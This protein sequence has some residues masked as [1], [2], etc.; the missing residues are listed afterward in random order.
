MEINDIISKYTAGE[1]TLERTNAALKEIGAGLV[2]DPTHNLLTPKELAATKAGAAP[3]EADGFGLLDTGT[4][5]LNK[6]EVRGGRLVHCSVGESYALCLI[7]G[8]VYHV[9]GDILTD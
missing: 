8:K 9:Q 4:G 1:E 3:A 5:T 7:G 2:L 6:V